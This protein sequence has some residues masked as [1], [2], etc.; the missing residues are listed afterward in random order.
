[1]NIL[2]Y[3]LKMFFAVILLILHFPLNGQENSFVD[4]LLQSIS[5]SKKDI[6]EAALS[7]LPADQKAGITNYLNMI[8]V[9]VYGAQNVGLTRY[10]QNL[11]K[12]DRK[13]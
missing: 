1:M 10:H 4:Q 5:S 8:G 12:E 2:Y 6:A 11:L 7:V 13:F 9:K 3:R